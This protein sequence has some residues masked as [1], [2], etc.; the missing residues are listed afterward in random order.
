MVDGREGY[1]GLVWLIIVV[2][3]FVFFWF[4]WR[5][6]SIKK[7]CMSAAKEGAIRMTNLTGT[8]VSDTVE[9]QRIQLG[10]TDDLYRDCLR[11]RGL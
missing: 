9:R 11:E 1:T 4:E 2:L 5:P 3:A 10:L 8:Y 7:F 6:A